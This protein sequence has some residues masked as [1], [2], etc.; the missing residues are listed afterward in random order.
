VPPPLVGPGTTRFLSPDGV[1]EIQDFMPIPPSGEDAHR[2][3][4]IRRVVQVRGEMRFR[5]EVEPRFNYG[6]DAHEVEVVEHG[7]V[8]RSPGLCLGLHAEA[9]LARTDGGVGGEFT[10]RDG[11]SATFVLESV[12]PDHRPGPVSERA[13][14]EAF[15]GTTPPRRGPPPPTGDTGRARARG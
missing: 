13:P 10:L 14:R 12:Q 11:E 2:H 15:E 1:S 4:L 9:K 8:F 7:A 3:R 6:R 5:V